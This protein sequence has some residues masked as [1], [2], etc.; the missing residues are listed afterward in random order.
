MAKRKSAPVKVLAVKRKRPPSEAQLRARAA[1]ALR[2]KAAAAARVSK[3]V[4]ALP[5][6]SEPT[7]KRRASR[8]VRRQKSTPPVSAGSVPRSTTG[9]W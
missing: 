9:L 2:L 7:A 1:G 8:K 5:R 3:P 4:S 6:F